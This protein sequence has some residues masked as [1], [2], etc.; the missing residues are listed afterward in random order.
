MKYLTIT[1]FPNKEWHEYLHVCTLEY[2]KF[3]PQEV[4][5]LIKLYKN[6]YSEVVNKSL[7]NMINQ[8]EGGKKGRNVH[9]EDG[10]TKEEDA[11]YERHKDYVNKGDYR[12][13]YVAFSHKIFALYQAYQF[14]KLNNY[15]YIIWLD[16]DVICKE[17]VTIEDI[18]G[19]VGDSDIAHFR[20]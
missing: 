11:F 17:E 18:D 1:T 15:E 6:K 13:E 10:S 7:E 20:S 3:F 4:P 2:L 9:I 12:T 16:A 14:A 5:L 19:W 8:Y